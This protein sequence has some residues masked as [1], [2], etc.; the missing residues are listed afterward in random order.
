MLQCLVVLGDLYV[1]DRS[2][3]AVIRDPNLKHNHM[4]LGA[5]MATIVEIQ[6]RTTVSANA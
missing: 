4:R 1:E 3:L 2:V 6:S 5:A